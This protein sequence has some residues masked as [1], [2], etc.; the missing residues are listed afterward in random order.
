[1]KDLFEHYQEQPEPLK[2]I[3]DK[4]S[5]KECKEGLDYNDCKAFLQEVEA[6]GYTFDYGLDAEPF[7]LRKLIN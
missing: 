6:I 3:C 7:N 4:W 5:D 1:M 2:A